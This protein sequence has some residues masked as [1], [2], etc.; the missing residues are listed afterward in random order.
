MFGKQWLN[1]SNSIEATCK[2]VGL[3]DETNKIISQS[4]GDNGSPSIDPA[5][6]PSLRGGSKSDTI[7]SLSA[8]STNSGQLFFLFSFRCP[9][10]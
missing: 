3:Q 4:A 7:E 6:Q 10:I 5:K 9:C 8:Q 2:K 1:A